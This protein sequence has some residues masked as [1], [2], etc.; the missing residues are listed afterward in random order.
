[1][2]DLSSVIANMISGVNFTNVLF[3]AFVRADPKSAKITF[4]SL[5]FFVLL[6]S[7]R[8]KAAN[9]MFVKSTLGVDSTNMFM[10]SFYTQKSL[11]HKK[12]VKSPVAFY[13]FGSAHLKA[14]HKTLV[15]LTPQQIE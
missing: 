10:C 2:F 15:N 11:E 14:A 5:V 12:T 1:M 4:K 8:V 7:V 9:K 13:T 6:G 3:E